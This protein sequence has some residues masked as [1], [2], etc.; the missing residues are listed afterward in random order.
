MAL[1]RSAA[2][3]AIA[4]LLLGGPLA[5]APRPAAAQEG[6]CF[7]ETGFCVQGRFLAY[8]QQHGGLAINGYPLSDE[9]QEL[10]EDGNT[11]TVQYFER[12]RLE[13]H[14]ENAP[15][16]DILLGQFGRREL[17]LPGGRH[18][19]GPEPPTDPQPGR[20]FFPAT[21][22]NVAPYFL[23]Y[24]QANGGLAQFGYP[25]T[26]ELL[27]GFGPQTYTVQYFERA[28]LERHP[29]NAPPYDILLGQ[30]GRDILAQADRLTGDFGRL[31][32]TD[33]GVQQR[34]ARPLAPPISGPGAVQKF[35][36]GRMLWR[37]DQRRI[38]VLCGEPPSGALLVSGTY[39]PATGGGAQTPYFA[40][41]WQEGQDPGGAPAPTPGQFSPARGFGKVWRENPD[42]QR[43]LGYALTSG[44]VGYAATA[45]EFERGTLLSAPEGRYAYT[46]TT[47]FFKCCGLG[48]RYTRYDLPSR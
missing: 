23:A 46:F 21:G 22:H 41:T 20:T 17:Y 43:C 26:E 6:A 36:H 28:R 19:D 48:G 9:R 32:L 1:R 37:G 34:L 11:Y 5:L 33:Q 29:E 25:L 38:Y 3:L 45:Q 44:E 10:L 42:V 39:D 18:S 15:P 47:E 7:Q 24:W 35:E 14:P 30:F 8:W 40:D 2:L 16:Y 13:L 4:A 27:E 31:Y 12:V